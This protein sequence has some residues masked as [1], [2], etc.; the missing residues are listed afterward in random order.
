MSECTDTTDAE[1]AAWHN[2]DAMHRYLSRSLEVRL[3]SDAALSAPEFDVLGVLLEAVDQRLRSGDLASLLGWEKSRLSHLVKRMGMRGLVERSEC[4]TDL[5]GTW[6]GITDAGREA[7]RTA[8]PERVAVMREILFDVLNP[9]ELAALRTL[10][11][12]VLAAAPQSACG[13]LQESS[14]EV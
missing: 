14:A 5:R 13:A 12:K 11:E 4:G 9:D 7:V 1:W 2:A 8:M 3:Q 6:I 10:S